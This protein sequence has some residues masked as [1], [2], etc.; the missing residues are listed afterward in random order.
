V[1]S[2]SHLR[3]YA[4]WPKLSILSLLVSR[5]RTE[6][7]FPVCAGHVE[8]PYLGIPTFKMSTGCRCILFNPLHL[9]SKIEGME[10]TGK[11]FF[12]NLDF[13][14]EVILFSRNSGRRSSI[15]HWKCQKTQTRLFVPRDVVLYCGQSYVICHWK[16]LEIQTEIFGTETSTLS[17]W[18]PA[19]MDLTFGAPFHT[20][21]N[22]FS[23]PEAGLLLVSTKKH[24]L[25]IGPVRFRF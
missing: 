16:F 3:P 24:D 13:P 22:P 23:S 1:N 2:R 6:T 9:A 25:W 7:L 4:T 18:I 11:R 20:R 10:I 12:E 15:C 21:Q 5:N 17:I 14:S 19:R 8:S